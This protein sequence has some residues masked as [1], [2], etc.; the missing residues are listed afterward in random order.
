MI[1]GG[2]GFVTLIIVIIAA[3]FLSGPQSQTRQADKNR[4]T[5]TELLLGPKEGRLAVGTPSAKVT[6][7]EFADFQ[8]PACGAAYPIVKKIKEEYKDKVYFV[9][10]HF[11]LPG[12]KNALQAAYAV[13]AAASQGKFWEMHDRLFESQEAWSEINNAQEL[14]KTYAVELGLNTEQFM[15]SIKTRIGKDKI[16]KDQNDGYQM[17]VN[18]TPTFFINGEKFTGVVDYEQFKRLLDERL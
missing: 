9:F 14:F 11:P 4:I 5:D 6:V 1:L 18:S 13:E 12:H 3:I 16:S 2:I 7:V 8:C 17:G 10:R 15:E